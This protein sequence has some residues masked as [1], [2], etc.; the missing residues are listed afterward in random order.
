[1]NTETQNDLIRAIDIITERYYQDLDGL[2][3]EGA[4]ASE[5]LKLVEDAKIS[6][7]EWISEVWEPEA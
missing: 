3:P 1:M 4:Y 5:W 6:Y 2:V 7:N